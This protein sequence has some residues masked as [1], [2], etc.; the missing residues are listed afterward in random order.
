MTEADLLAALKSC[1]IVHHIPGRLRVKLG[2]IAGGTMPSL[3]EGEALLERLRGI[4]GVTSVA[5][6][7]LA[8]SCTVEYAPARISPAAWHDLLAGTGSDAANALLAQFGRTGSARM[9]G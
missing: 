8:R 7:R 6:N 2:V 1:R 4:E 9:Q 5:V 3:A